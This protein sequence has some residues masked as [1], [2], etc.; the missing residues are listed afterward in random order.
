RGTSLNN[1]STWADLWWGVFPTASGPGEPFVDVT[2]VTQGLEFDTTAAVAYDLVAGKDTL[3]RTQL[4]TR[5]P[6]A[7]VSSA[8]CV[9]RRTGGAEFRIPALGVPTARVNP[10]PVFFFNG[11]PVFDCWIPG[12]QL[13]IPG[14]YTVSLE[15]SVVGRAS[16]DT[17]FIDDPLFRPSRDVR[18]L[19]VPGQRLD[20]DT[21][22]REW[23]DDLARL[24]HDVMVELQRLLP[25]R[26]G[27]GD[28]R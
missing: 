28:L 14:R 10:Y 3:I 6:P 9:I 27:S 19:V 22:V 16:P 25:I 7:A 26:Q 21:D 11:N 8:S 24:V 2:R 15:V 12:A 23:G 13:A 1:P 5:G 18:L 17:L 20:T 4:A